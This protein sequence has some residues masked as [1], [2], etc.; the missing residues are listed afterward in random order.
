VGFSL[1]KRRFLLAVSIIFILIS[2]AEAH[3]EHLE[4]TGF[5]IASQEGK[6][7]V[8][9]QI[10]YPEK[11]G[12]LSLKAVSSE[13]ASVTL[14]REHNG[15]WAKV[16]AL[17]IEGDLELSESSE[18]RMQLPVSF[19]FEVLQGKTIPLTFLFEKGGI[20]MVSA[21]VGQPVWW[22]LP[23]VWGLLLVGVLA[24]IVRV[25]LRLGKFSPS[26]RSSRPKN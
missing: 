9:G 4:L 5:R 1:G 21:R 8:L 12:M 16:N 22:T 19:N 25:G 17:P 10:S 18:Y 11:D 14:E 7:F 2:G 15:K 3:T 26:S 23:W 6:T 20:Q 13:Y 24:V